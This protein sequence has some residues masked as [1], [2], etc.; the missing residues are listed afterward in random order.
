MVAIGVACSLELDLGRAAEALGREA[1][2]PGR[3]ERCDAEGDD[4]TVFVDYAHTPDAL[5][6]A[7][8]SV[9]RI[10]N[11]RVW[12]VFGCGGDRDPTKRRPMG[13]AAAMRA[14]A[15]VVTNDNPR[16]EPPEAIAAASRGRRSRG[17][18]S[19]ARDIEALARGERG[20]Y[21]VELDRPRAIDLAVG[22]AA[23]G[24]VVVLAGKG[25]ED[26]QIVGTSKRHLDDRVEA[27]RAPAERRSQ[28]CP[29]RGDGRT[30]GMR[31]RRPSRPTA[32]S[33]RPTGSR[34]RRAATSPA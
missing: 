14:D 5:G 13:E 2:A 21:L 8:D 23:A 11:G 30:R 7:L 4:V 22:A 1:G 12:C 25:H 19:G 24:D 28:R 26:Y 3:L 20:G 16:T 9:R 27:R 29:T 33:S 15:V 17:H 34:R 31:W 18:A 32:R 10:A 6:R